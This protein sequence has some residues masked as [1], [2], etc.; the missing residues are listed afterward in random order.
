MTFI[1]P[2]DDELVIAGQGTIGLEI[3]EQLPDVDVILVP[4]GDT[5]LELQGLVI[6]NETGELLWDHLPQA[7]DASDLA[8]AM[9]AEYDVDEA[10]AQRDAQA[11]LEQLR[12]LDII[13][14]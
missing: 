3:L 14:E 12:Q 9:R 6:L 5:S 7:A 1:H 11:F 2:Y 10:T 4:I 8:A 13:S